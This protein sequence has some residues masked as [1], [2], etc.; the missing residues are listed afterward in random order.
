[1]TI[2]SE[3]NKEFEYILPLKDLGYDFNYEKAIDE[4]H[5]TGREGSFVERL[6]F[7]KNLK[8]DPVNIELMYYYDPNLIDK[9]IDEISKNSL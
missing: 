2:L 3:R 7:I 8:K 9:H 6:K 4:A 5:S 1:M